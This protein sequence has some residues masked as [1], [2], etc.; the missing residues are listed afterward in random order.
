MLSG[1]SAGAIAAGVSIVVFSATAI[2]LPSAGGAQAGPPAAPVAAAASAVDSLVTLALTTSPAIRA[3]N[4]RVDAAQARIAPAGARPDPTLMAGI[5]NFPISEPGFRDFM[6]MKMVGV[7]QT[8]P[9][10]GKL[11]RQTTVAED[12]LAAATAAA[13]IARRTVGREVRS[14]YYDLAFSSRALEI[15][16]RTQ[17]IV[18]GMIP[19]IEAHYA[20]GSATQADVLRIRIEAARLADDGAMVVEEQ[21]AMLARVNSLLDRSLATP[22]GDA[23]IPAKISRAAVA[24][25]ARQ[26]SFASSA[27]GARVAGSPVM[28]LDS[29]ESIARRNSPAL[30]QRDAMIAAQTARAELAR[31]GSRPDIDVSL[32]YGQRNSLSDMVTAVVSIPIPLQRRR[33]QDAEVAGADAEVRAM[34]SDRAAAANQLG[35][36]IARLHGALERDRTQLALYVKAVLPQAR[37]A[38]ASAT[39]GYQTGRVDFTRLIDAQATLFSYETQYYRALTDFAKTLAELEEQAGI[40]V[41]K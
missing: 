37:A 11:S 35:S 16:T 23:T 3:A 17:G 33:K 26:I 5:Q 19:V 8:F 10:P 38:L 6:T 34:Q 7:S 29:I 12:E 20:A 31:R 9:Y 36:E 25:T 13:D 2:A 28:A 27:L 41:L 32:Q 18:A 40:E 22:V 15:V 24:D 4:A 14:A 21:R 39:S 1:H 30:R